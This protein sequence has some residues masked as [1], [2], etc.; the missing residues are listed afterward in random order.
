MGYGPYINY[1][2]SAFC[3][4]LL[5]LHC[6]L[7]SV[8]VPIS[9]A[10]AACYGYLKQP[11]KV[12]YVYFSYPA[13]MAE[14]ARCHLSI[15]SHLLSRSHL[16]CRLSTDLPLLS[17]YIFL[18]TFTHSRIF[19]PSLSSRWS[20]GKHPTNTVHAYDIAGGL[21][22]CA[23]WMA[24]LGRQEADKVCTPGLRVVGFFSPFPTS[25]QFHPRHACDS[26]ACVSSVPFL[27][28]ASS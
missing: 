11:M 21:W 15:S 14:P 1:G 28:A 9:M 3:P 26:S 16:I 23:E 18:S 8:A 19:F 2:E 12:M 10:I 13:P 7:I 5:H 24:P 20:P 4:F 22:A 17:A 27:C 25:S 6:L